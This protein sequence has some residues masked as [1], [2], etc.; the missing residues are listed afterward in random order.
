M[1][2]YEPLHGFVVGLTDEKRPKL[3]VTSAKVKA[4][5]VRTKEPC[6]FDVSTEDG[7]FQKPAYELPCGHCL[8][9][10][11]D[12][13]RE[14]ANRLLMESYYHDTA[15]FCTFTYDDD[16]LPIVESLDEETGEYFI[17]STLCKRDIQLFIKRLRRAFPDDHIRYSD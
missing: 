17:H 2:C 8:G 14:W 12:Q 6:Y 13:S 4:I 16:H 10:R 9:C 5:S 7:E 15:Y 11:E 3:L 1:A